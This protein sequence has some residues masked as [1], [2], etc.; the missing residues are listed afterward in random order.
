MRS[1]GSQGCTRAARGCPGTIGSRFA[2]TRRRRSRNTSTRCSHWVS[3]TSRA[4]FSPVVTC[5]RFPGCAVPPTRAMPRHR[6]NSASFSLVAGGMAPIRPRP[7]AGT[8]WPRSGAVRKRNTRW[9]D[10]RGR[11]GSCLRPRCRGPLVSPR[12]GAGARGRAVSPRRGV[13]GRARRREGRARG[14]A[15]VSFGRRAGR[16]RF[17]VPPRIAPPRRR[18]GGARR[19][20]G[21]ALVSHGRGPRACGG[22]RRSRCHV[23]RG[24]RGRDR[25]RQSPPVA[26][27]RRPRRLRRGPAPSRG[28]LRARRGRRP[29]PGRGRTPVPSGG[30]ARSPRGA[31]PAFVHAPGRFPGRL[32]APPSCR[33]GRHGRRLAST[34]RTGGDLEAQLALASFYSE[35]RGGAEDLSEAAHWLRRAAERGR[36]DA[37][38]SLGQLL[39]LGRG[40]RR[41]PLGAY[42]WFSV[43]ARQGIAGAVAERD[44]AGSRLTPEQRTRAEGWARIR[45]NAHVAFFQ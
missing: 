21:G 29:R 35:G 40:V 5:T 13:S 9:G 42:M 36:A 39:A 22:S 3:C 6:T 25:S 12:G 8:A 34:C 27:P 45:W 15:V 41:D 11:Q 20:R 1:T 17:L 7:G 28:R 19:R 18:G 4:E 16:S 23:P 43:A 24:P 31:P 14:R 38:L 30:R 10:A 33:L 32:L 26:P 44:R 2:G 37:Q